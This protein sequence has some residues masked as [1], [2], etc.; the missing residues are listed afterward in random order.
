LH[1]FNA[2]APANATADAP[3]YADANATVFKK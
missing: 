3:A 1:E 2:D